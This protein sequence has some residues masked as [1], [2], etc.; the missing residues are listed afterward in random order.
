MSAAIP[1]GRRIRGTANEAWH[2]AALAR[3]L[4]AAGLLW[5]HVPNGGHR[6]TREAVELRLHGVKAGVPDVLIFTPTTNAPKGT[7]LELKSTSGSLAPE[8]RTWLSALAAVGW[9]TVVAYGY[10]DALMQLRSLGYEV[11]A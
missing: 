5:C 6:S 11:R 10:E 9:A 2:Q 4:D 3:Y 1:P 8:Q 7:A